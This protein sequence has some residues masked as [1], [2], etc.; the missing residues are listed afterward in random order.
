[1]IN[2]EETKMKKFASIVLT[3]VFVLGLALPAQAGRMPEFQ[4]PESFDF[5]MDFTLSIDTPDAPE[6]D[7]MMAMIFG[8]TDITL[9]MTGSVVSDGVAATQM[10]IEMLVGSGMFSAMPIRMWLD[11]DFNDFEDPTMLMIVELPAMLRMLL[12]MENRAFA[13]QFLVLDVSD[14]LAE[15]LADVTIPTQYEMEAIM[16]EALAELR[17]IDF[18]YIVAEITN[19][20][21]VLDFSFDF[22]QDAGYLTGINLAF[23]VVLDPN[24]ESVGVGFG[25]DME[26]TNINNAVVEFPTLT[27]ANS[28]DVLTLL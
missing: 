8:G 18:G 6:L 11:M 23:D 25:F 19:F 12:A 4:T 15:A 22:S 20:I 26:I 17:A 13:R 10:H 16:E 1:M 14:M 21:D 7:P 2:K 3:L 27:P 9:G 28:V 5:A 24:G